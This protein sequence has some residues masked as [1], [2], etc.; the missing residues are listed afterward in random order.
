MLNPTRPLDNFPLMR[1][2]CVE[3]VR[4]MLAKMT[5]AKPMLE[6]KSGVRAL[7][8][9]WNYYQFANSG[10]GYGAYGA[11]VNLGLPESDFFLQIFPIKG[12]GELL[13]SKTSVSWA[14]HSSAAVSSNIGYRANYDMDYE[15]LILRI[16]AEALRKKL[17]VMTA[18][19]ISAP[20]VVDPAP[21]FA[22]PAARILR[23]YFMVLVG[24]L[25]AA[26]APLP[27]WA[28]AETEQ[29]LM[30]MFLCGNRHNYSYLL[31]QPPP[32]VASWQVRRAEEYIEANWD[33]PVTLEDLAAVTGVSTFSLFRSFK[34]SRGYTPMQFANLVRWRL[35]SKRS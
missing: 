5:Y 10:L 2:Q 24:E 28:Q 30:V 20:V 8:V 4:H 25:S 16:N 17:A 33:R 27:E 35:K 21:D 13:S 12:K 26:T 1:T 11:A 31:A 22:Q 29:L 6:P 3:Q 15:H 19:T 32:G 18:A 34:K 7:D 9:A 23:D 14:L